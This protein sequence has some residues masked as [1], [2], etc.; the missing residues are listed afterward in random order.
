MLKN[1]RVLELQN[2]SYRVKE[3]QLLTPFSASFSASQLS[4]VIGPNGAGKSTLLKLACGE[5]K[6]DQGLVLWQ[7]QPL[8]SFTLAEM[9]LQRAVLEQH[10]PLEFNFSVE[11]VVSLA[12]MPHATGAEYDK[13]LVQLCLDQM[14]VQHLAKADYP[15]LSGGEKQRVQLARVL[16]QLQSLDESSLVPKPLLLALD[17]PVAALDLLHQQRLMQILKH[18]AES[19]YCVVLVLHDLNLACQYADQILILDKGRLL[20]AGKVDDVM[21]AEKLAEVFGL[22]FHPLEHPL[23]GQRVFMH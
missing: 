2:V 15:Q 13:K 19:G 21:Q 8:D 6:P 4:V 14:D 12:R 11:E 10:N 3:K 20:A 17:E 18:K 9:A 23:S 16:A 5:L 7:G 1:N 22:P